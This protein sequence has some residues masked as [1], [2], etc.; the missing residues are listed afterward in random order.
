MYSPNR[1]NSLDLSTIARAVAV[2]A[3][4]LAIGGVVLWGDIGP[5]LL[6]P[7]CFFLLAAVLYL[8]RRLSLAEQARAGSAHALDERNRTL[9]AQIARL[10]AI[11]KVAQALSEAI[12]LP[13]LLGQGLER[14]VKALGL[15]GGQI[16]LVSDDQEQVMRLATVFGNDP[17]NWV[18]EPTIRVGECICGEAAAGGTPVVVEDITSDPRANGRACATGG[19]P[20]VASVPL[21]TQGG[22]LGVLSVRSCDPHHFALHDVELLTAIANFM[23]AAIENA[24]IRSEMEDRITEL[25]ARVKQLAI[26]QERERLGREM[27]DGLAQTLSLLNLQIELVKEATKGQD[28]ETAEEELAR[29]DAHLLNA[30]SDVREALNNLRRTDVKGEGFMPA[31]Q[32]Y[33]EDFGRRNELEATLMT[34]NGDGPICLPPLVEVQLHRVIHEALTNVRRHSGASKVQVCVLQNP[35]GWDIEVVDNGVGFDPTRLPDTRYGNYG[36]ATMRER[37]QSLGGSFS[38]DSDPGQGTRVSVFVPCDT[39]DQE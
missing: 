31:L 35:G 33:L 34:Q 32:E 15:D 26:V 1:R 28:W 11:H 29:L 17:H 19:V 14:A 36:L 37:V 4:I 9:E 24:R 18:A 39:D 16:H 27:H 3:A 6:F 20:S 25:S 10:S 7:L 8:A 5:W 12:E 2:L 30:Y 38:L 13:Q 23:A 21:R 22:S